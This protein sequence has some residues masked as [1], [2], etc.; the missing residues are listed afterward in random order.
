MKSYFTA[1]EWALLIS[2][3]IH[4]VL[5]LALAT[6]QTKPYGSVEENLILLEFEKPEEVKLPERERPK[7]DPLVPVTN[8]ASN[9][10]AEKEQEEEEAA[11][12]ELKEDKVESIKNPDL[13]EDLLNKYGAAEEVKPVEK[14]EPKRIRRQTKDGTAIV[15]PY[16]GESNIFY[17][18][19]GRTDIHIPN[20][21]YLCERGGKVVVNIVV[22]WEGK[23]TRAEIN[24]SMSVKENYCL[25]EQ[26]L[27]AA[28]ASTFSPYKY[29]ENPELGKITFLFKNQ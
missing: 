26:A 15:D 29:Y 11:A 19:P 10:S 16:T 12:E 9:Q 13:L 5:V 2:L 6:R 24:K 21:I 7:L 28:R 23:V 1:K 27:E 18:L 8:I 22:N 25:Y 14:D 4:L 20:P 17:V 3:I